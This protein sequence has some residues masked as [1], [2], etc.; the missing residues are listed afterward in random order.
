[1]SRWWPRSLFGRLLLFLTGG[2]VLAQLL[3][4]AI[5]LQD[6]DQTLYHAIGGHL[7]QRIAAIVNLFDGLNEAERRRLAAALCFG[8]ITGMAPAQPARF[9]DVE[10]GWTSTRP[11]GDRGLSF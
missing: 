8:L 3:S 9:S 2:L 4:A 1:M 10:T 5:L 11:V 7:A 6:R